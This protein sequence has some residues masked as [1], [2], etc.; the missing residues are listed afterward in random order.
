MPT[1][2][3]VTLW[4]CFVSTFTFAVGPGDQAPAWKG[5]DLVDARQIEFPEILENKPAVLVFWA[6][7]C[8]YC[9]AF[10]PHLK[11]LQADYAKY[12]VKIISF[13]TKERG[14]GDAKA[15]VDSLGFPFTAIADADKIADQYGVKFIPGLMVLDGDGVIAYRR[16]ST[17]LPAGKTVSEQWA[18]EVRESLDTLIKN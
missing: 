14:I 15:Y 8:P 1:R 9:K 3:L 10:M 2:L 18:D 5:T 11:D 7:W 13:N 17:N 6:T 12:G 16:A 4:L